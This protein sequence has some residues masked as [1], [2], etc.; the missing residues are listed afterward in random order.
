MGGR[1]LMIGK[2]NNNFPPLSSSPS[3]GEMLNMFICSHDY[4]F[5]LFYVY[6]E[7]RRFLKRARD[8]YCREFYIADIII[9]FNADSGTWCGRHSNIHASTQ[10]ESQFFFVS[11]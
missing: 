8:Y 9:I 7:E 11:H 3:P 4:R 6:K 10:V 2:H 1:G 5:Q